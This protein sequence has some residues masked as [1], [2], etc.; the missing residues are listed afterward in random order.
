METPNEIYFYG[1]GANLNFNY[2]SNFYPVN[3]VG[4]NQTQYNCTEQYLMYHKAKLFEPD[5]IQLHNMILAENSPAKIKALG[6]MVKNYDDSIWS[7]VRYNIMVDGL[8]L[9][10]SQNPHILNLLI[11]TGD[12]ILYEAA[13]NDKIWGIGYCAQD[14]INTPKNKFGTNLLGNALMQVRNELKPA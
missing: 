11:Q 12:K 4:P 8:R 5:N 1:H 2:M 3:F 14:A 7:Q 9:K 13:K 10:F 6:R